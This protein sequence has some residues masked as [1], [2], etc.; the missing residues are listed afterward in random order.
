MKLLLQGGT[1]VNVFTD[2]TEKANV[3]IKDG[4]IIGVGDYGAEEAD[5]VENIEGKYVCP[6]LIDGHIHIESTTLTPVELA[7]M[8]MPHGTTS[9]VADP[10]EIANVCGVQGI[11]Y[12]ME[13]SE[14][15]P[16]HVYF[17]LPSCVPA[18]PLDESGAVLAAEDLRPLYES[19]RVVALG[20]M[21]N[22]PGVVSGDPGVRQK[23]TDAL[24]QGRVVDGHAP[25]LQGKE[26]DTYIAAGVQSDH[27]CTYLEEALEKIRKGQ[28]I[29]IRQGTAARN[30]QTLLPLPYLSMRVWKMMRGSRCLQN[31]SSRFVKNR[32]V[33]ITPNSS[34]IHFTDLAT[35]TIYSASLWAQA[36]HI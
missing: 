26:L 13:A 11:Q 3:L 1:V 32:K 36:K 25:F 24:E 4:K 16:L 5:V 27:E 20:E 19:K 15:L 31:W 6:G 9:I 33:L 18:T 14:G 28:W 35:P 30:L 21:M 23:I 12:L 22:Y 2:E 34:A 8:C 17:T 7:K 10:H 29:M